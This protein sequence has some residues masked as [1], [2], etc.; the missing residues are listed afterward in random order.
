MK[1]LDQY[2][3]PEVDSFVQDCDFRPSPSDCL[4]LASGLER[5]LAAQTECLNQIANTVMTIEQIDK[6]VEETLT[7]TAKP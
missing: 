6:L 2:E 7:L 4:N 5:R 3:T 1:P